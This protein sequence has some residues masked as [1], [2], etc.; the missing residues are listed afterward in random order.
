MK[1]KAFYKGEV[2]R[3]LGRAKDGRIDIV[4]Q[5]GNVENVPVAETHRSF[6]YWAC[7][8][9]F[10]GTGRPSRTWVQAAPTGTRPGDKETC[11]GYPEC[12][13]GGKPHI[14]Y[15]FN[16]MGGFVVAGPYFRKEDA[17]LALDVR[18]RTDSRGCLH[19]KQAPM[20]PRGQD[21]R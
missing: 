6:R 9:N 18:V 17:G 8:E 19:W 3:Y 10:P 15:P 13:C 4:R 20:P 5:N 21:G 12:L 16:G 11:P 14:P 1:T 7:A 2:V